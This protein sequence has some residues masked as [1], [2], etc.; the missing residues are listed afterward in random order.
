[1]RIRRVVCT[2]R[3]AGRTQVTRTNGCDHCRPK[4]VTRLVAHRVVQLWSVSSDSCRP[5]CPVVVWSTSETTCRATRRYSTATARS[6]RPK[7]HTH[8]ARTCEDAW[9]DHP[10][11]VRFVVFVHASPPRRV[12]LRGGAAFAATL[13]TRPTPATFLRPTLVGYTCSARVHAVRIRHVPG[14]VP[15]LP[16]GAV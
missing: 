7:H 9:N 4:I 6:T 16:P 1:L 11:M 12:T 10:D 2:V 13:S 3:G 14:H 5:C 15:L 8:T